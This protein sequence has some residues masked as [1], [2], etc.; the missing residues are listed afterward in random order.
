MVVGG[1]LDERR[2]LEEKGRGKGGAKDEGGDRRLVKK[3]AVIRHE[4]EG[5]V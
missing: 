3:A 4:Y 1:L 2:K 5:C